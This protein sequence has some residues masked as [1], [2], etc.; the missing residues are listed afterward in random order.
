MLYKQS[1][2]IFSTISEKVVQQIVCHEASNMVVFSRMAFLHCAKGLMQLDLRD[3]GKDAWVLL[4]DKNRLK[5]A[6]YLAK[7]QNSS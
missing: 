3:D 1:L 7:K 6:Y 5:D 2:T 4:I